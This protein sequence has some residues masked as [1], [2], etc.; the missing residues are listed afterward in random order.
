MFNN[1]LAV[2]KI[3]NVPI[4]GLCRVRKWYL[5]RVFALSRTS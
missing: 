4:K 2:K 1:A 5:D 3:P